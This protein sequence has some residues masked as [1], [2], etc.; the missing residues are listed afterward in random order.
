MEE[1]E[2]AAM[3]K[4]RN[5]CEQQM[6]RPSPDVMVQ[7][8]SLTAPIQGDVVDNWPRSRGEAK[9]IKI[10]HVTMLVL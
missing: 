3:S 6:C 10:G 5:A 2:A 1:D 9:E 8:A 4:G 7:Q